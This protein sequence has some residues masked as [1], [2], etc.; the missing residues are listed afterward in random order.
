MTAHEAPAYRAAGVDLDSA[1]EVVRRL[2]PL[3]ASTRVPGVES[4]LGSFGGFFAFPEPGGERLLIASIDGVGTKM[5]VARLT[6]RWRDAGYDIVAHCVDDILVHGARPLFF[7]D[8]IGAGKLDVEAIAALGE[9]MAE[10]CREAGCALLG[11]ETAEM[12]GTYVEG[13][14]DLVGCI[15]GEVRRGRLLPGDRVAPGDALIGL[16]SWGLHTNGYSLARRVLI[17]EGPG[18][19]ARLEDGRTIG[20]ALSARHRM[21]LPAVAPWLDRPELHGLAHIT[22]GGIPGN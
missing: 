4:D 20:E 2:K 5:K 8:Y 12:P 16:A 22:G 19:D 10:A 11:G 17:D 3:A 15:V 6:G 1:D 21:Y 13:E 7:L 18:I 14:I 9:G